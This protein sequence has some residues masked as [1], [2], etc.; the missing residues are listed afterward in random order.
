MK[1][2]IT[3]LF[4]LAILQACTKD[5]SH[6]EGLLS[7]GIAG[8]GQVVVQSGNQHGGAATM[9]ATHS[10]ASTPQTKSS[11]ATLPGADAGNFIVN[12]GTESNPTSIIDAAL[13]S[14]IADT[15]YI[16][17]QGSYVASAYNCTENEAYSVNNG[18]GKARYYGN[19]PFTVTA[20]ELTNVEIPCSIVN[21]MVSVALDANFLKA[22]DPGTATITIHTDGSRSVRP[23]IF[24][25][26]NGHL[27]LQEGSE[28]PE[29]FTIPLT[30][31]VVNSSAFY[32]AGT[33]LYITISAEL[34][35]LTGGK[36]KTFVYRGTAT[37]DGAVIT[38]AARSWHKI[39][40]GADL[41]NAPEGTQG[42][43]IKV[44]Q[45]Q[46]TFANSISI[47]GYQSGSLN[48]DK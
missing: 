38:T 21:S 41:S 47:N 27:L 35:S 23:L 31:D 46:E 6:K 39:I 43:T 13:F 17:E 19:T 22:F 33:N 25:T 20:G 18:Y 48:E 8:A 29:N 36:V 9:A 26:E 44:G 16:V 11:T 28:N 5:N 1:R 2:I 7:F 42:I 37:T 45:K 32:P 15:K 40:I 24:T 14:S 10:M 30:S 34:Q 3:I 12:A 4:A